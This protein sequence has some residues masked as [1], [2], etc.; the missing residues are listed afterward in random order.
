MATKALGLLIVHVLNAMDSN[1][2]P[3]KVL[4]LSSGVADDDGVN[5]A[6]TAKTMATTKRN[7]I[8]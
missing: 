7:L 8:L 1:S 4:M 5:D 6:T 2:P 3:M